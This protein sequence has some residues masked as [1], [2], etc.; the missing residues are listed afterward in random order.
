[1]RA[2]LL[3]SALRLFGE[4]GYEG[5][6]IDQIA[7]AADVARQTVLNHYPHKRDFLSAWGQDRRDQLLG[8]AD[9]AGPDEP[10]RSR[11]HRYYT[12]LARMNEQE[13]DLTRMLHVSLR[14]EEV[15]S[16]QRPIPDAVIAALQRGVHDGEF[17]PTADPRT[18]A[19][20]LTAIY[21]D[22]LTRWLTPGPP[23]FDLATTLTTKVDLLITGLSAAPSVHAE[24]S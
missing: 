3:S 14:H 15:L 6:T 19:E 20:I 4:R 24:G 12:A 23:P 17:A 2:R 7:A 11:L 13:R 16:H 18:A 5:T 8:L 21:S 9:L 22:T 10:A 1:M